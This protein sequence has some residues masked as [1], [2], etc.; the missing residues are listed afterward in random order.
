MTDR[1]R[2]GIGRLL[3][4]EWPSADVLDMLERDAEAKEEGAA[5]LAVA[6]RAR[7]EQDREKGR[8]SH[9][10][11]RAAGGSAAHLGRSAPER[12]DDHRGIARG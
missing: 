8:R 7:H 4:E 10:S 6:A 1:L 5:A 3:G 11:V 9:A 2:E 12:A